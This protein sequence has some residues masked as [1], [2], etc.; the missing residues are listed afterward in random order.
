MSRDNDES[1]M[2][3]DCQKKTMHKGTSDE[4]I[5]L[6]I[7]LPFPDLQ[8]TSVYPFWQNCNTLEN[9]LAIPKNSL[10]YY[11][12]GEG[13]AEPLNDFLQ[14]CANATVYV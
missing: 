4:K 13:S 8:A 5:A 11:V 2:S 14:K 7:N 1:E 10:E 12:L 3:I 9:F 6:G